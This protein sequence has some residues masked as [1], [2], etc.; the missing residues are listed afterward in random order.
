VEPITQ[1][2]S[3]EEWAES[4][5][6]EMAALQGLLS[7]EDRLTAIIRD[8]LGGTADGELPE[9]MLEAAAGGLPPRG[10]PPK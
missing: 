5:L 6:S 10:R 2:R 8:C 7:A 1:M 4:V 9:E 3:P